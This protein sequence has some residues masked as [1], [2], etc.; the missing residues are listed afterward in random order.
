MSGISDAQIEQLQE[1]SEACWRVLEDIKSETTQL[2][3][4]GQADWV[5]HNAAHFEKSNFKSIDTSKLQFSRYLLLLPTVMMTYNSVTTNEPLW[6]FYYL[7][8]WGVY[9]SA[10][11]V[12]ATIVASTRQEWQTTAMISTQ[13]ATALNL[14][15]M[16]VFWLG[17]APYIFPNLGW[18]GDDLYMRFHMITLH[19]FPFLQ[20]TIN[21]VLTDIEFV[22][23]DW[24]MMIALGCF[25]MFA[26]ALGKLDCGVAIYPVVDWEKPVETFFGWLFLAC[27]MSGL[28]YTW[29][30]LLRKWRAH[31]E[32]DSHLS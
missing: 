15:I 23:K 11:S 30:I 2:I 28:Y 20:T 18:T 29:A 4:L 16:V 19:L 12:V 9:V 7:T 14:L 31:N 25:Y 6:F 3:G 10:F 32:L 24:P 1:E 22:E 5:Y 13:C 8:H 27:L 26:N 21:I 17:L